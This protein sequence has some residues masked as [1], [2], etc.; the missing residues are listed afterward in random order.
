MFVAN[1][2][3][4]GN[5]FIWNIF[6]PESR[7][8]HPMI[9]FLVHFRRYRK[10][11]KNR[12]SFI[13]G[14]SYSKIQSEWYC[15]LYLPE[16]LYWCSSLP[17]P[18]GVC[19]AGSPNYLLYLVSA[20]SSMLPGPESTLIHCGNFDNILLIPKHTFKLLPPEAE[21]KSFW[22]STKPSWYQAPWKE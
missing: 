21:F 6:N 9:F 4:A 10:P 1:L 7:G 11:V 3:G 15:Y 19:H 12:Y 8:C 17:S 13:V 18:W 5:P 2:S 20:D 16:H 22:S 14:E